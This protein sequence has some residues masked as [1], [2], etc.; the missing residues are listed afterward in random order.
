MIQGL[1][2]HRAKYLSV[3]LDEYTNMI[4][5]KPLVSKADTFDF[6][7]KPLILAAE[8][9]TGRKVKAVHT[10]GGGEYVNA[11]AHQF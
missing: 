8:T 4:W 9:L 5:A 2:Y 1:S 3:V 10:D 7:L 6:H 11:V